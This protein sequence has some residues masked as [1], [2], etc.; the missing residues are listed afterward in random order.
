MAIEN[1]AFESGFITVTK[2][3]GAP[4]RYAIADVLRALDIPTG[5]TYAQVGAIKTLANLFVVLIRTLVDKEILDESFGESDGDL[6]LDLEHLIHAIEE[7][8]GAYHD[9][10]LAVS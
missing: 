2:S 10:D 1:L 9:P 5:L 7:M 4:T 6:S 3:S 8:G